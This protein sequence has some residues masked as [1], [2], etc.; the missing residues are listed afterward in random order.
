MSVPPAYREFHVRHDLLLV[1]LISLFAAVLA[2]FD[3][4]V[5]LRL[6]FG[7]LA[8]LLLPGY[9]LIALLF[10]RPGDLNVAERLALSIGF[11]LAVIT[12]LALG[13]HYSPAGVRFGPLVLAITLWTLLA[14]AGASW[15]REQLPP[16][17]RYAVAVPRL[18]PRTLGRTTWLL[19]IVVIGAPLLAGVMLA[20]VLSTPPPP[21]TEF[22]VLGPEGLGENYPRT[23]QAGTPLTLTVGVSNAEGTPA[24]YEI[25]VADGARPLARVGQIRLAPGQRWEGPVTFTVPAIG[26]DQQVSFQ[27][28]K[29]GRTDSYRQLRLWLDV[30]AQEAPR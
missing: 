24:S 28:F 10:P 11:S 19:L 8:V 15:R 27:L 29:D 25:V 30:P 21:L 3:A 18:P 6:P 17:E 12:I 16:R 14:T 7:L 5:L 22:Y 13:L 26:N 2:W 23:A 20:S 9:S 4:P 1:S